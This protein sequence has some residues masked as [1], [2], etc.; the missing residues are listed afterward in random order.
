MCCLAFTRQHIHGLTFIPAWIS[1]SI[2]YKVWDEI[3]YPFTNFN[4]ATIE[5]WEW[6]SNPT[7]YY[8]VSTALSKWKIDLFK[9]FLMPISKKNT[10]YLSMLGLKLIHVS[11][12]G[13]WKML[14][15]R[16][17]ALE[18]LQHDRKYINNKQLP[19]WRPTENTSKS[20]KGNS[21]RR[22]QKSC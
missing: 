16:T 5:V 22:L 17:I 10:Y 13:P 14:P 12:R 8:R 7:L 18:K 1:K 21:D 11:K 20:V 3:T 2:S 15:R 4:G 6:I 19:K 9:N